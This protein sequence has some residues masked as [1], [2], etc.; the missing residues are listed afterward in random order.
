MPEHSTWLTFVLAHMKETLTA[1]LS[2]IGDSIIGNEAPEWTSFEP[3]AAAVLTAL[4][5]V[6]MALLVRTK[7]DDVER[8]VVPEEHLTLRTAFEVFL[9]YFYDLAKSVMDEER[10][11]RY[12]PVIGTSA[13]FVFSCNVLAL[14]PINP[15]ATSSLNITLGCALVVFVLFNAYGLMV[16]GWGYLK[17]LAGP[18]PYLAVLIFPIEVISLCV[19]PIT[20]AVRLMLNMAV[21]HLI[22]LIFLGIFPLVIPLPVQFLGIIIVIVQT[23]VFTLLTTIYIGM[24]TEHEAHDH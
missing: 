12:F 1:N 17:H 4:A 22:F 2:L 5:I 7:L 24:A 20:L 18:S 16:N 23:L 6:V 3:I 8:A 21:D 15:V 19:R 13:L 11:K 9:E 10:A 14:L